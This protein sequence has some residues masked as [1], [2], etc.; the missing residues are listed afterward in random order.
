MRDLRIAFQETRDDLCVQRRT[1]IA[2]CTSKLAQGDWHAVQDA[3]SDIR[4]INAKIDVINQVLA[5]ALS[6]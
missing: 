5:E 4:E 3:G 1:L 6:I 2:Y